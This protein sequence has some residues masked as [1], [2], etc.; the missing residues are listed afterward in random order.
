MTAT[1]EQIIAE[2]SDKSSLLAT[3]TLGY[4]YYFLLSLRH[5]TAV[6]TAYYWYM[7]KVFAGAA[8]A[9]WYVTNICLQKHKM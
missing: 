7:A 1:E 5:G 4:A 8:G 9:A 3:A 6:S 2:I